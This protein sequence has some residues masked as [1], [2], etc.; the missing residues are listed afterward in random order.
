MRCRIFDD[1]RGFLQVAA[2][3]LAEQ[4]VENTVLLGIALHC[5]RKPPDDAVMAV[6]EDDAGVRLAAIMTPPHALVLSAGATKALPCLVD[7]LRRVGVR[8]SGVS[9][10]EPMAERFATLW[11]E[12]P[13]ASSRMRMTLY[14]AS[15]ITAPAEVPGALR[16]AVAGDLDLLAAWQHRF[17]VQAGLGAAERNADMHPIVAARIA[18]GEMFLWT[19]D[20]RPVASAGF[21]PNGKL[22][23]GSTANQ[24]NPLMDISDLK[25][26]PLMGIDVWEHAY[27][28]KYQNKRA[29]YVKAWWNLVN[30]EQVAKNF[31]S[32]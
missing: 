26:T 11:R 8:P 20:G 1:A 22:E 28:L 16:E 9:G 14:Q 5:R 29:D 32:I 13:A 27:Y 21:A 15:R 3:F 23:I 25:G 31:S 2:A 12:N 17:A 7:A 4:E 18:R 19:V 6:V 10:L 30:W 24:D